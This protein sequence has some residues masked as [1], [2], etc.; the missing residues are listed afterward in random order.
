MKEQLS[1]FFL[2]MAKYMVAIVFIVAIFKENADWKDYLL[3]TVLFVAFA[4]IGFLFL[5]LDKKNAD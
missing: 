3:C 5:F 1:N 4:A 2:D